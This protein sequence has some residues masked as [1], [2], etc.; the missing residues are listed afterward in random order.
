VAQI[1]PTGQHLSKRKV[2]LRKI[3]MNDTGAGVVKRH[4]KKPEKQCIKIQMQKEVCLAE[5]RPWGKAGS[6]ST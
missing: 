3:I 4:K 2:I 6:F 1:I 5:R